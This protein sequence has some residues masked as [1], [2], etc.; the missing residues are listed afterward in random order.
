MLYDFIEEEQSIFQQQPSSDH[1]KS[2]EQSTPQEHQQSQQEEGFFGFDIWKVG[3]FV[4]K[5]AQGLVQTVQET[6]W[7]KELASLSSGSKEEENVGEKKGLQ[8]RDK[9]DKLT[10]MGQSIFQGT[11]EIFKEVADSIDKDIKEAANEVKRGNRP[12][13]SAAVNNPTKTKVVKNSNK[14]DTEVGSMQRS[15]STYIEEPEDLADFQQFKDGF[16]I[17][18]MQQEIE[19]LL[20]SNSFMSTLHQRIVPQIVD[21]Y[22]F[23]TRYFYRLKQLKQKHQPAQPE[24]Q[25]K[26]AEVVIVSSQPQIPETSSTPGPTTQDINNDKEESKSHTTKVIE[27]IDEEPQV[28]TIKDVESDECSGSDSFEK[29]EI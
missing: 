24:S 28:L 25:E 22:T 10:L 8:V 3:N 16:Q 23:W 12:T 1:T 20:A 11:K 15:S 19:Q 2:K 9:L 14:F 18:K 6:D 5:G 13:P 29:V 26:D 27:D 7:Q 17:D 4:K 21:E